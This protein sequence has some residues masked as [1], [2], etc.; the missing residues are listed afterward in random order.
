M[1]AQKK[2]AEDSVGTLVTMYHTTLDQIIEDLDPV[3]HSYEHLSSH[4]INFG[5]Y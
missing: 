5:L 3:S 4:I 2:E 1:F